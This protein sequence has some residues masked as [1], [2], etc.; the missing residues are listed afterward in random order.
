MIKFGISKILFLFLA[1]SCLEKKPDFQLSD[2]WTSLSFENGKYV[3]IEPCNAMTNKIELL[4]E[5]TELL[6]TWGQEE[7]IFR[8]LGIEK[9][10]IGYEILI[11]HYNNKK[12]EIRI[13]NYE[14]QK[15]ITKWNWVAEDLEHEFLMTDTEGLK[16]I[17]TITRPCRDCWTDEECSEIENRKTKN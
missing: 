12:V 10:K 7:E 5:R 13:E 16:G 3:V 11:R 6:I 9:T 4:K 1:I 17:Q 8:I 14:P 15:R 2:N